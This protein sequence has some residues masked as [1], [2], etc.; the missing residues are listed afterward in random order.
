MNDT[1]HKDQKRKVENLFK[2]A[3]M[4][5]LEKTNQ[6]HKQ[7]GRLQQTTCKG[8]RNPKTDYEVQI[9]KNINTRTYVSL[10]LKRSSATEPYYYSVRGQTN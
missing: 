6:V 8:T 3:Q 9:P 1:Q 4:S 5:K 2:I 7:N 10:K